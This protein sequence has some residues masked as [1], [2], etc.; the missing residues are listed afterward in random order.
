MIRKLLLLLE[1][2]VL[3]AGLLCLLAPGARAADMDI[4]ER[5]ARLAY[6][7]QAGEDISAI[8]RLQRQR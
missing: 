3:L 4:R 6:D 1:G 8:K 2:G 5:L 7:V